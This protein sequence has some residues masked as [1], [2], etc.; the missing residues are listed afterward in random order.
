MPVSHSARTPP[1]RTIA[2]IRSYST[3]SC[4]TQCPAHQNCLQTGLITG[5][6]ANNPSNSD[7]RK[8]GRRKI[9]SDDNTIRARKEKGSKEIVSGGRGGGKGEMTLKMK[10]SCSSALVAI[11]TACLE[12]I[13]LAWSLCAPRNPPREQDQKR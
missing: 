8:H 13:S 5:T 9:C 2:D 12:S 10:R 4:I 1:G 6:D 3:H 7:E 11:L